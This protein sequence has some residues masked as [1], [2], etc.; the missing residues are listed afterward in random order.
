MLDSAMQPGAAQKALSMQVESFWQRHGNK[1]LGLGAAVLLYVL[2]CAATFAQPSAS[3]AMALHGRSRDFTMRISVRWCPVHASHL[4]TSTAS[5]AQRP[6]YYPAAQKTGCAYSGAVEHTC[7]HEQYSGCR[8][9]EDNVWCDIHLREPVRDHGRVWLPGEPH[10]LSVLPA[11]RQT[12][13]TPWG[14]VTSYHA[15]DVAYFAAQAP[16]QYRLWR[17]ES[18]SLQFMASPLVQALSA[19]IIAFAGLYLRSRYSIRP[20]AVYRKALVQLNTNPAIL[21]VHASE[22]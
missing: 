9:Q 11:C 19:A 1:V 6:G 21:E 16:L 18:H 20:D 3:S 17:S 10:S 15:G 22:R 5:V 4:C 13:D 2:W 12:C 7:T 8:T 14:D